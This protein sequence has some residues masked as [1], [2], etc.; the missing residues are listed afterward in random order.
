MKSPI[1]A[2]VVRQVVIVMHVAIMCTLCA[3]CVCDYV[4]WTARPKMP[5]TVAYCTA[6]SLPCLAL[7]CLALLYCHFS[8]Y[9]SKCYYDMPVTMEYMRIIKNRHVYLINRHVNMHCA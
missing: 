2:A 9:C 8:L 7:P 5:T 4:L 6:M 3:L 1:R